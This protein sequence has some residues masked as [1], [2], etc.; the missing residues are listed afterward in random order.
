MA[1]FLA[2]FARNNQTTSD[3]W[4]LYV[5]NAPNMK[6]SQARIIL[7]GPNDVTLEHAIK[8]NFKASNNQP[9][10]E[11]LIVALKLAREVWAKKL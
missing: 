7:E 11:A 9:K 1:N 8:L 5:D 2:E 3:W 6:G 4:S 10:Y